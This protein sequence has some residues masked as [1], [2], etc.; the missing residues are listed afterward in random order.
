MGFQEKSPEHQ[1]GLT[2]LVAIRPKDQTSTTQIRDLVS[3]ADSPEKS[4]TDLEVLSVMNVQNVEEANDF[5]EHQERG[6]KEEQIATE[7]Q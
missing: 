1:S 7:K 6:N 4:T 2:F 3:P 5:E